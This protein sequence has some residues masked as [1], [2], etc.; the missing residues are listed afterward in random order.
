MRLCGGGQAF[1]YAPLY[2]PCLVCTLAFVGFCL[3]GLVGFFVLFFYLILLFG[4]KIVLIF[5]H[6][7]FLSQTFIQPLQ[8]TKH[9]SRQLEVATTQTLS[10]QVQRKRVCSALHRIL[11]SN[12]CYGKTDRAEEN[13]RL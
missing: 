9:S 3:V 7:L 5:P 2:L 10:Q 12:K 8:S 6:H 11:G 13:R 4:L 1:A